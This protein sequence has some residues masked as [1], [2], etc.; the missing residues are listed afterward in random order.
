MAPWV[1]CCFIVIFLYIGRN[2]LFKINLTTILP[3]KSK[4][5]GKSQRFNAINGSIE[6]L[7]NSCKRSLNNNVSIH[8]QNIRQ[9]AIEMFK[10]SK[11]LCLEIVKRLFQFRNEI[12]NNLRQRFQFHIPPVRAVF[13]PTDS[14][15]FLGPKIWDFI[16]DE[17]KELESLGIQTSNKAVETHILPLKDMQ[18]THF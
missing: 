6:M 11:G 2:W 9:L 15:K 1:I 14:I 5:F 8:Y 7:K 13:S 4:L 10:V 17:M 12:L 16:P 3:L 18:T